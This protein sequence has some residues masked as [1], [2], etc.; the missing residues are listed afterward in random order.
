MKKSINFNMENI[1]NNP[2]LQHIT[3]KILFNLNYN[4]LRV[5]QAIQERQIC[6]MP[7]RYGDCF[8]LPA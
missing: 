6:L 1:I 3:E 8:D 7:P 2:G 4:D 5:C